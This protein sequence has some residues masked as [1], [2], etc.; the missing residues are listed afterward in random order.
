MLGSFSRGLV[1][2]ALLA[3]IPA[4]ASHASV[5][6]FYTDLDGPSEAPPNASP[7]TGSSW[8]RIDTVAKTM[9]IS[10]NFS[11]LLGYTTAAHIH[12][13]TTNPGTGTASVMTPVP[14]F[15]DFPAGVTSGSYVQVLDLNQASSYNPGFLNNA[16]NAGSVSNARISLINALIDGKAY[17][18]I[19]TFQFPGGEI[20]GFYRLVPEPSSLVLAALAAAGLGFFYHAQGARA[21]TATRLAR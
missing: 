15:P 6:I 14:S 20:R 8:V 13:P 9:K 12:G 10:V 19:H 2:L 1:L 7:A 17:L 16:V 11:G 18:N 21:S 5:V 3:L 4:P